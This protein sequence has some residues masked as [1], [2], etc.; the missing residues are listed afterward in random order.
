MVGRKRQ[1]KPPKYCL[2]CN[3]QLPYHSE[4]RFCGS[5]CRKE[6]FKKLGHEKY[7]KISCSGCG[8]MFHK[9]V[10]NEKYCSVECRTKTYKSILT[11]K[12]D[13]SF[14]IFTRDGF[15]CIYCGKSSIE[16]KIILHVEHVFP[17]IKGGGHTIENLVTA[18]S[19]CNIEKGAKRLP[20]WIEKRIISEINK[21]NTSLN[22]QQYESLLNAVEY[23]KYISLKRPSAKKNKA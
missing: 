11:Y 23:I 7:G 16:D 20:I 12:S 13:T 3:I 19:V 2:V 1:P 18:C 5:K 4:Y 22:E 17:M 21:R 14:S 8:V 15:T 6:N 9:I 10:P